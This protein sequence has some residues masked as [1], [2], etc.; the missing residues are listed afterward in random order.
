MLLGGG[1]IGGDAGA[2]CTRQDAKSLKNLWHGIFYSPTT[3]VLKK[4][5]CAPIA[6]PKLQRP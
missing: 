4:P 1:A 6:A 5:N 2:P 3:L